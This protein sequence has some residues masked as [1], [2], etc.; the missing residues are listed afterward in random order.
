MAVTNT[1]ARISLADPNKRTD[2]GLIMLDW[3]EY[4]T[5]LM[6]GIAELKTLSPDS[7]NGYMLASGAG[8][9]TNHLDAKTR[10]LISLAVA[11]TTRCDGCIAVHSAEA[12]KEGATREEIAEALGVAIAMNTGAALVY[13]VRALD[14]VAQVTSETEPRR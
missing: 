4:K 5:Q 14:A 11:V 8:G 3:K 12:V 9:K 13:S 10:Q 6:S 7:V 1:P 2:E